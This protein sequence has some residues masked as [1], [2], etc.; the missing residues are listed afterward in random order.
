MRDSL[1]LPTQVLADIRAKIIDAA[2]EQL[3]SDPSRMVRLARKQAD[4][5]GTADA[6]EHVVERAGRE[7]GEVRFLPRFLHAGEGKLH[8]ADVRQDFKALLAEPVAQITG[9]A[10]KERVAGRDHDDALLAE[11]RSQDLGN[12][13]EVRAN[14]NSLRIDLRK[15]AK[16]RIGTDKHFGVRNE[17]PG[18]A[19]KPGQPIA[20]DANYVNLRWV[21]LHS[22]RLHAVRRPG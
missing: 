19:G 1:V 11:I 12:L 22:S 14:A 4:R 21:V 5:F 15:Q 18:P 10:I 3:A 2:N 17:V 13:A 20:A 7:V 8:A 9:N 6:I 16:R